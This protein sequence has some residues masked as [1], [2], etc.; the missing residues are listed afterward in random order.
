[1]DV[2]TLEK[3][4]EEY[5]SKVRGAP[6]LDDL[7]EAGT[8]EETRKLG[9]MRQWNK[10]LEQVLGVEARGVD[11]VPEDERSPEVMRFRDYAQMAIVWFSAN[12]TLNN[13]VVGLLG[14]V[15][16]ELGIIDSMVIGT[17]G[18]MLGCMGVAYMATFGPIS[19]NRTLVSHPSA[20][21]YA[22]ISPILTQL[23]RRLSHVT[24]WAGG[25]E[26]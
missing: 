9:V 23:L 8:V 2:S 19:G 25:P 26:S 10:R 5:A 14:P 16:Y 4:A 7:A 11:R 1:M 17:F 20:S 12:V 18:T 24:R 15:S 13:I 21:E 3:G 22:I 6:S